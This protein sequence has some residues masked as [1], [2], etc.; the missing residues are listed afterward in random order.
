MAFTSSGE[1]IIS[2]SEDFTIR[3]DIGVF[4]WGSSAKTSRICAVNVNDEVRQHL[5]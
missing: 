1:S 5:I 4:I 2:G 3:K